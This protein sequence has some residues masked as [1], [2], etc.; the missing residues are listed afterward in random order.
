MTPRRPRPQA[1]PQSMTKTTI[2]IPTKL[3]LAC[4]H[5]ALDERLDFSQ[6]VAKALRH[7]LETAP[8]VN[9]QD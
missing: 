4:K 7:Y 1:K 9:H 6:V 8:P 2:Y 5:R 3:H